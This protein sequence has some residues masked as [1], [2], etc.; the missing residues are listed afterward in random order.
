LILLL[1]GASAFVQQAGGSSSAGAAETEKVQ[2]QIQGGPAKNVILF[3]GDGMGDSE[4]AAARNYQA[5]AAGRLAMDTLPFTGSA[6]R[7]S[8]QESKSR[9]RIIVS[10]GTNA[11]ILYAS[12][13]AVKPGFL[14]QL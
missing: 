13:A 11:K 2:Q 7:Y 12:M 3:I 1:C 9:S 6:T 5:G 14:V 4:I 10:S 8:L